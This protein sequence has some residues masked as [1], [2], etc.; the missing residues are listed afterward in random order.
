MNSTKLCIARMPKVWDAP[1]FAYY[2]S[3]PPALKADSTL[4][5]GIEDV[6]GLVSTYEPDIMVRNICSK[7]LTQKV[8]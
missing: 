5:A 7:F 6:S 2:K 1:A 8:S 3:P 4:H